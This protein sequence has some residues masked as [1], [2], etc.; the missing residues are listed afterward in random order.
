MGVLLAVIAFL[1]L[2]DQAL[3]ALAAQQ[4]KEYSNHR[5]VQED[6]RNVAVQLAEHP[7]L[8]ARLMEMLHT[9]PE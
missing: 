4:G 3:E 2:G 6:L 1:D 9:P 7:D 5:Q 8:D